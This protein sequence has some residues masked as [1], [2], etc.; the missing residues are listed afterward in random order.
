[1]IPLLRAAE[2][3]AL[4]KIHTR[5]LARLEGE[6][7]P[8]IR[9]GTLKRYNDQAVLAWLADRP[10]A[11]AGKGSAKSTRRGPGRPRNIERAPAVS[12]P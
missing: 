8:V 6:G 4:L 9:I 7:L 3:A 1:M 2:L 10:R 11:P 12:S 5:T